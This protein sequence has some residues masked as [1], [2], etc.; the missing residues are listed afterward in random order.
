MKEAEARNHQGRKIRFKI[1]EKGGVTLEN[2]L[3]RSNPWSEESCGRQNC[4]PCRGGGGGSI[5][6]RAEVLESESESTEPYIF[7]SFCIYLQCLTSD[8][9]SKILAM[10]INQVQK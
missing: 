5:P 1:I 2:L 3:R 9:E 8:K 7:C 6:L 4:F 10:K